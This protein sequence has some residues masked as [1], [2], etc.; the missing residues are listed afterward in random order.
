[1]KYASNLWKAWLTLTARNGKEKYVFNALLAH[2][3]LL[4]ELVFWLILFVV[5]LT[6]KNVPLVIT[7]LSLLTAVA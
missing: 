4:I 6:S 5:L 7:L 1:M 3:L 2:I